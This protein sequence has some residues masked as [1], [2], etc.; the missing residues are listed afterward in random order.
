MKT[1]TADTCAQAWLSATNYLRTKESWS[2]FNVILEI[3]D[4]MAVT[5]Q[6]KAVFSLVD[7][8]LL[9]NETSVDT[10]VNTIFPARLYSTNGAKDLCKKYEED[11]KSTRLN[12]SHRT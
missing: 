6:D 8:L 10:V 3:T 5:D 7:A 9:K 11:R 12:S 4:P 1:V 2:D